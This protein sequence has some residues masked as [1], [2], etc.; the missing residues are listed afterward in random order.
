MPLWVSSSNLKLAGSSVQ[1]CNAAPPWL[2]K[3]CRLVKGSG[4]VPL[5]FT[6]TGS[7]GVNAR[8]RLS[9]IAP[10]SGFLV[11]SRMEHS[12][13]IVSCF[14]GTSLSR[15]KVLAAG[16]A[17]VPIWKVP[18][19]MDL[20]PAPL[21]IRISLETVGLGIANVMSGFPETVRLLAGSQS[22]DAS[23]EDSFPRIER[24]KVP[25]LRIPVASFST[26]RP[27]IFTTPPLCSNLPF[28]CVSR[29]LPGAVPMSYVP[30]VIRMRPRL[31][32]NPDWP[33]TLAL[34]LLNSKPPPSGIT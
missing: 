4:I 1:L 21:W 31:S 20:I 3:A 27:A 6:E 5:H 33:V 32:T 16:V 2:I 7:G 12:S 24:F 14:S 28:W 25:P 15:K 26:S 9:G 19:V 11:I 23:P 13:K 17:A 34:G 18:P 30:A 8:V 29:E 10:F 22:N